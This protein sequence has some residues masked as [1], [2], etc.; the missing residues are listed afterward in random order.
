MQDFLSPR[1]LRLG[2]LQSLV[3]RKK[4]KKDT[5]P[6]SSRSTHFF[7]ALWFWLLLRIMCGRFSGTKEGGWSVRS[8]GNQTIV[9]SKKGWQVGHLRT[10]PMYVA[11]SG[12]FPFSCACA[13]PVL[14][15]WFDALLSP[16]WRGCSDRFLCPSQA[17]RDPAR[18]LGTFWWY[19]GGTVVTILRICVEIAEIISTDMCSVA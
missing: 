14:P 11:L 6:S 3:I 15:D 9:L 8:Y 1:P 10:V 12:V 18:L 19:S 16:L 17:C 13:N 7:F 2:G 4:K 5:Q